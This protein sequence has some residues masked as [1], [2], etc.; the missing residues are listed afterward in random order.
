MTS[1]KT[2]IELWLLGKFLNVSTF[3]GNIGLYIF[4]MG[5][6]WQF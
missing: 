2:L 3:L 1:N 5:S 6:V 4:V